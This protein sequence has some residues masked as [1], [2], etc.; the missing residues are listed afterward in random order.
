MVIMCLAAEHFPEIEYSPEIPSIVAM[1]LLHCKDSFTT[2]A[3]FNLISSSRTPAGKYHLRLQFDGHSTQLRVFEMLLRKRTPSM[4]K[5]FD[6]KKINPCEF[7]HQVFPN[8]F[9]DIVPLYYALQIFDAF[10]NEGNKVLHRFATTLLLTFEKALSACGSVE[11]IITSIR[12]LCQDGATCDMEGIWKAAYAWSLSRTEMEVMEKV[13]DKT[14]SHCPI[15]RGESAL[16]YRPRVRGTPSVILSTPSMWED[17]FVWIPPDR[18]AG[19]EFYQLYSTEEHGWSLHT[20]YA[21]CA[22]AASGPAL[23]LLQVIP[24][25]DPICRMS[26]QQ[27][28]QM[29]TQPASPLM[30]APGLSFSASRDDLAATGGHL[31]G[32]PR[33]R[34]FRRTTIGAY[35]S[36]APHRPRTSDGKEHFSGNSTSFVFNLDRSMRYAASNEDQNFILSKSDQLLIGCGGEGSAIS[37]PVD[38]HTGMTNPCSTFRNDRLWPQSFST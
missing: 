9:S 27:Q 38:F 11:D 13:G 28:Q 34:D 17:I 21:R 10:L 25:S 5:L 4:A 22:A 20:L 18:M 6:V 37:L 12:T 29:S 16:M 24:K 30:P 31:R 32:I 23:L 7:A 15:P 2:S 1:L 33:E 26:T 3:I 8:M 35:L 36:H 19:A 14:S